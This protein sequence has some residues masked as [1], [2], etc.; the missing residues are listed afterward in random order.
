MARADS[1][2]SFERALEQLEELVTEL[3]GGELS[4]EA[5]LE[6]FERG[7]SLVR[8]CAERLERAELRVTQL[9]VGRDGPRERPLAP[10]EEDA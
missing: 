1:P 8:L 6:T 5:S 2:P 4:L 9:E 3:E 10:E 7:I